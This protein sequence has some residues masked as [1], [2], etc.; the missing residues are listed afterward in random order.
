MSVVGFTPFLAPPISF[1]NFSFLSVEPKEL[2]A[3]DC[4]A[5]GDLGCCLFEVKG[6]HWGTRGL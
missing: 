2:L 3:H 4:D 1:K 6:R 5:G